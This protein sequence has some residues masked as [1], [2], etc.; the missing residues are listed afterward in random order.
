MMGYYNNP[1]ATDEIIKIH[2]DGNRWLHTGDIGY[3]DEDGVV[4]VTGRIKRIIMTRGKDQQVTKLFP[5]RIEKAVSAHPAVQLCCVIGIPDEQR[6][7]RI[8]AFVELNGGYT[9]SPELT[10]DIRSCCQDRLPEYQI[11]DMIEFTAAMPRTER[12]K[13]DYR[14]LEEMS[15]QAGR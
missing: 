7:N 8:K 15:A 12:G 6:I 4:F 3:I 5:D 10:E 1:Q 13:I 11:P 9:P 2:A 14:A